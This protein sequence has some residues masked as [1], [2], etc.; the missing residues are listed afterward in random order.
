MQNHSKNLEVAI[1]DALRHFLVM[2]DYTLV[3]RFSQ[4]S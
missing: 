2:T 4:K 3:Q 1:T